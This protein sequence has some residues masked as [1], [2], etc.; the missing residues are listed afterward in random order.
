[1]PSFAV[2]ELLIKQELARIERLSL[3]AWKQIPQTA[4]PVKGWR[5]AIARRN[6]EDRA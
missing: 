3:D 2:Q 6:A 5:R 1:M 4:T